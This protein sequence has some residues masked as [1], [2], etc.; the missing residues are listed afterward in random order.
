MCSR[1]TSA[2]SPTIGWLVRNHL[3]KCNFR[4]KYIAAVSLLRDFDCIA[5]N[6]SF[7]LAV[8]ITNDEWWMM[9]WYQKLLDSCEQLN[10]LLRSLLNIWSMPCKYIKLVFSYFKFRIRTL[11]SMDQR[12]N[13]PG[14][15]VYMS[16]TVHT[17][18]I[19]PDTCTM[20]YRMEIYEKHNSENSEISHN[21]RK[22]TRFSYGI[23]S[24]F[25]RI[26]DTRSNPWISSGQ[27]FFFG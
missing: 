23:F 15:N 26:H 9:N 1:L 3:M 11:C 21:N 10:S 24:A 12:W 2:T 17:Y 13:S 16:I 6:V 8:T 14:W 7:V 5:V 18:R 19:T 20:K 4:L 22:M 25:F 27:N